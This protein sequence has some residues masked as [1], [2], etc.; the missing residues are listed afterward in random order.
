MKNQ[1]LISIIGILLMALS[2]STII[3][4]ISSDQKSLAD[5]YR[6]GKIRLIHELIVAVGHRWQRCCETKCSAAV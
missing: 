6:T 4:S 5:I 3:G 2:V 1:K